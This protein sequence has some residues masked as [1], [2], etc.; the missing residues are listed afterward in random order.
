MFTYNIHAG[1]FTLAQHL[2]RLGLAQPA[3]W[4]E[5]GSFYSIEPR[6]GGT[7][8]L[9]FITVWH[10]RIAAYGWHFLGVVKIRRFICV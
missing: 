3:L 4:A 1:S 10:R 6:E 8:A 2:C 5:Q 9:N 7:V